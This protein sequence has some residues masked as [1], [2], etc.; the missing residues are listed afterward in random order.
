M[1]VMTG[2]GHRPDTGRLL[3][4][5]IPY[6][7]EHEAKEV[8]LLTERIRKEPWREGGGPVVYQE[9]VHWCRDMQGGV[10][11]GVCT[12]GKRLAREAVTAQFEAD[13]MALIDWAARFTRSR[14]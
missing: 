13:P 2:L 6:L 12:T 5:L 11:R 14:R 10:F 1:M 3:R 9:L 7:D 8:F 4:G